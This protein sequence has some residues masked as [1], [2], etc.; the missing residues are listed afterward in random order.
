SAYVRKQDSL[1][2]MINYESVL[3]SLNRSGDL[4]EPLTL[5]YPKDGIVTAD[6][7]LMLLNGSKRTQYQKLVNELRSPA[8]QRA[9]MTNTS[10]RPAV[11]GIPLDSRFPKQVLVELAFPSSLDVVRNLLSSYL[12]ELSKPS[13]TLF[14][15]DVSGSMGG[16]RIAGLKKAMDGLA[17]VDSS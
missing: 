17:G 16:S 1:G 2:G 12:N 6:Y 3:L 11:P 9:L 15:L 8:I 14:V 4:H 10:R 7:P 5:I 13:H